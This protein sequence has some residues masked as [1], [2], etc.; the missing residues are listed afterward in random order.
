MILSRFY[1][2]AMFCAI[3][4]ATVAVVIGFAVW[5]GW[6]TTLFDTLFLLYAPV[7]IPVYLASATLPQRTDSQL[8]FGIVAVGIIGALLTAYSL[9]FDI[10]I[11]FSAAQ[12]SQSAYFVLVA[13]RTRKHHR[14]LASTALTQASTSGLFGLLAWSGYL[15]R[16]LGGGPVLNIVSAQDA[17]LPVLYI[18]YFG[19]APLFFLLLA[20]EFRHLNDAR[21]QLDTQ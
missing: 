3:A 1:R 18:H 17:L 8:V 13:A 14:L 21:A 2:L 15:L 5:E 11:G 16:I 20:N 19:A 4:S 10:E 7:A 9:Q 12:F 6:T